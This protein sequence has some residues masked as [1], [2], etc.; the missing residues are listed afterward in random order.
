[1][2][3]EK[4]KVLEMV[5]EGR[6][7]PEE[8]LRLI[9]ALGEAGGNSGSGKNSSDGIKFDIPDIKL[10]KIDLKGIGEVAVEFQNTMIDTFKK[11][12][13]QVKRSNASKYTELKDFP[14]K[15]EL[16][17]GIKRCS[18][19]LDIRAGKVKVKAG[20]TGSSL[21]AGKVKRTPTEPVI[22]SDVKNGKVDLTLKHSIG[23][24]AFKLNPDISYVANLNNAAADA[25]FDLTGLSFNDVMIDNQAGN[26]TLILGKEE[27]RVELDVRNNAGS[28]TVNVPEN[29]ALRIEATGSLSKL[30]LEKYGMELVDGMAE[31]SDW[32]DNPRGVDIKLSQ[33]VAAFL[34]NW[35]RK[36]GIEINPNGKRTKAEADI[37]IEDAEDDLDLLEDD[38]L[39][40]D[41]DI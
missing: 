4:M 26:M 12:Q 8:G 14:V 1:M 28:I 41:D 39:M 29:Y 16:P 11:T 35:K 7:S 13:R 15:V 19:N 18:L 24:S 22:L 21:I 5:Q 38:E 33:N 36:D 34:L 6:L 9:E 37:S 25:T 30:N 17:K 23:R 2:S 32:D 20:E 3:R 27:D 40:A 10:P 31:S